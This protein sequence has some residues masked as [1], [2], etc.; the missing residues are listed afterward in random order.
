MSKIFISE[1]DYLQLLKHAIKRERD[2]FDRP[3]ASLQEQEECIEN[4]IL[5]DDKHLLQDEIDEMID[6]LRCENK[7]W[8]EEYKQN[9]FY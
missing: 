1:D 2:R 4:A 3:F 7:E 9:K 8:Y 5:M 6:D